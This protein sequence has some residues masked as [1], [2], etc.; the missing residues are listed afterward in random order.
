MNYRLMFILNAV[1]VAVFGILLLILPDFTLTQLGME[2][3][4]ST[5][6]I[7]RFLG[8]AML[9]SAIF[10]WI[11]KEISDE[12][13][14]KNM[15]ITLLVASLAGFV[16]IVMGVASSS[17]VIRSNGWVLL[18]IFILF[19]LGYGYLLSGISIV[20]KNRQ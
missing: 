11:A 8:G 17:A 15:A 3:Y 20:P 1:V 7:A 12:G 10:I 4:I 2:K 6:Y 18:V 19:T 9:V 13:V 5:L 16:L 14:Q